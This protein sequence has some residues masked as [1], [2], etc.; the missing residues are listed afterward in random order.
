MNES[1]PIKVHSTSTAGFKTGAVAA[2]PTLTEMKADSI[3]IL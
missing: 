2:G 1:I 3:V